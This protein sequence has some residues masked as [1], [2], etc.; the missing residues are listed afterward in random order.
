MAYTFAILK[1]EG[2]GKTAEKYCILWDF[3]E[4]KK[5]TWQ[6]KIWNLNSNNC[7]IFEI[8]LTRIKTFVHIFRVSKAAYSLLYANE[9][10]RPIGF[11]SVST[12]KTVLFL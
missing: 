8:V 4:M 7:N 11:L 5:M 3:L 9:F 6:K 12:K 1:K 2:N 10:G